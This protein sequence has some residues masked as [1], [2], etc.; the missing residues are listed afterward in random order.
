ML[1]TG[2]QHAMNKVKLN[3]RQKQLLDYIKSLIA[4]Y[5]PQRFSFFHHP[6]LYLSD[7][8]SRRFLNKQGNDSEA[9]LLVTEEVRSYIIE[10]SLSLDD[11]VI[12]SDQ[13]E[14]NNNKTSFLYKIFL[15]LVS[16]IAHQNQSNQA[17]S[18][19]H[20]FHP[21]DST[22][23]GIPNNHTFNPQLLE[24]YTLFVQRY[25]NNSNTR[26]LC[27]EALKT[28]Y[29]TSLLTPQNVLLRGLALAIL[30]I[31]NNNGYDFPLTENA[32]EQLKTEYCTTVSLLLTALT[33]NHRDHTLSTLREDFAREHPNIDRFINFAGIVN[34][35]VLALS[36][37]YVMGILCGFVTRTHSEYAVDRSRNDVKAFTGSNFTIKHNRTL[38]QQYITQYR[39][40]ATTFAQLHTNSSSNNGTNVTVVFA[41]EH[42]SEYFP[43]YAGII[44]GI[45]AILTTIVSAT[46]LFCALPATM[47]GEMRNR[48]IL[49][50]LSQNSLTL[51]GRHEDL[52]LMGSM[53]FRWVGNVA[54]QPSDLITHDIKDTALKFSIFRFF[55]PSSFIEEPAKLQSVAN[56]LARS[57]YRSRKKVLLRPPYM[58]T[59]FAITLVLEYVGASLNKTLLVA[60]IKALR[61]LSLLMALCYNR[62]RVLYS[63][64]MERYTCASLTRLT[65]SLVVLPMF[66]LLGDKLRYLSLATGIDVV[67]SVYADIVC[68]Q[69]MDSISTV[70]L[71]IATIQDLIDDSI[72]QN[73]S[74]IFIMP[75]AERG[76]LRHMSQL[77]VEEMMALL[78]E[79]VRVMEEEVS[80]SPS[81]REVTDEEAEQIIREQ[82]ACRSRRQQRSDLN[83]PEQPE[84]ATGSCCPS[85][86]LCFTKSQSTKKSSSRTTKSKS[87][88]SS[89]RNTP[90]LL[91]LRYGSYVFSSH[92]N[93]ERSLEDHHNIPISSE[94]TEGTPL[95][96]VVV[97][98]RQEGQTIPRQLSS[99]D[100]SSIICNQATSSARDRPRTT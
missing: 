48:Y 4:S 56:A 77:T 62:G 70:Q 89:T 22:F 97:E 36:F 46:Q 12:V 10:N 7:K 14:C 99:V 76:H 28:I 30:S 35:N 16:L 42:S 61:P 25:L 18:Q 53:I 24:D 49:D 40:N 29:T 27:N 83:A 8:F 11:L 66:D 84:G 31:A 58:Y 23:S 26:V 37:G 1:F 68:G 6:I 13:I 39:N 81:I 78:N 3:T 60:G 93:E 90:E 43:E 52:H 2:G 85:I 54:V 91:Q 32:A 74:H 92:N 96:S 5:R 47:C 33:T 69:V 17:L 15:N 80:S 34:A 59:S 82:N 71:N 57:S 45:P 64:S 73:R 21:E 67:L 41:P 86:E 72:Q 100:L 75:L 79:E 50:R 65:S 98:S 55:L 44:N 38:Y 88:K 20:I 94:T 51:G 95:S 19:E 63:R 9:S 87:K